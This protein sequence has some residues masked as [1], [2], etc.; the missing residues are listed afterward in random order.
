MEM[1]LPCILF[2]CTKYMPYWVSCR[3][4]ESWCGMPK[5][6]DQ[7]DRFKQER[8]R[9][10]CSAEMRRQFIL[11]KGRKSCRPGTPRR[12]MIE[13]W[14]NLAEQIYDDSLGDSVDYY[15]IVFAGRIADTVRLMIE[16]LP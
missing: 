9:D 6:P 8:Y 7:I 13:R 15:D 3:T 4:K 10:R 1:G 2:I 5:E 16:N 12:K 14:V 11:A